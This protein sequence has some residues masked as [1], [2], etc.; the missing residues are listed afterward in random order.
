MFCCHFLSLSVTFCHFLSLS[1]TF[2]PTFGM[3]HIHVLCTPMPCNASAR[4]CDTIVSCI[5]TGFLQNYLFKLLKG[6]NAHQLLTPINM[7][8]KEGVFKEGRFFFKEGWFFFKGGKCFVVTFC[9][10]LSLSVTFC[11]FLSLFVT[12]STSQKW[13]W[14][15]DK[16]WQKVINLM[17]SQGVWGRHFLSL[18]VTFCHFLSL[19]VTICHFL[20]LSVTF[21]HFLSLFAGALLTPFF[22]FQSHWERSIIAQ[23]GN[24]VWC[25][26]SCVH[27]V[28]DYQCFWKPHS[29]CNLL[30]AAVRSHCHSPQCH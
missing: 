10:F 22:I 19:S 26:R 12:L 23:Y 16:K 20:S 29:Q 21:C 5:Q 1:V 11:H 7:S 14:K 18:S 24:I 25:N 28:N 2:G 27:C 15:S 9:H 30:Q 4:H 6:V 8:V 17:G 13:A 3:C